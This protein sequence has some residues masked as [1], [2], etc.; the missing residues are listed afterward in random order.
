MEILYFKKLSSSW[1]G[2]DTDSSQTII[3]TWYDLL[4]SVSCV[5]FVVNFRDG[6]T[7]C[8]SDTETY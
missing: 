5:C 3:V 8:G 1:F 7:V 4:S 2:P 6:T